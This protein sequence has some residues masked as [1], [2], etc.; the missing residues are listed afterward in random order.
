MFNVT[1]YEKEITSTNAPKKTNKCHLHSL[2]NGHSMFDGCTNL[3]SF[4]SDLS[5]LT[6][7]ESMFYGCTNLSSFESDLS[8]LTNG[9][10]MFD[11]C[12]N[13]SSFE[14]DLSSLTNGESMFYGCKLTTFTSDLSSLTDGYEM[15]QDCSNLTAFTADLSSLT[16]AENMF[17]L[18]KLTPQS[19]MYI[20][21]SIK[22]IVAEKKLYQ[23]GI[24]PYVTY[25]VPTRKY[26]AHKGFMSDGNY[27]Y[28]Y[29]NPQP[30]TSIIYASGVG[31]LTIGINVTNDAT[32]IA[33]QLQAFAEEATFNSWED[34]KQTFVDKGWN[35]TWQYCGAETS[36]TYDLRGNRAIPCP[37]YTQLIEISPEGVEYDEEGNETGNMVYTDEQKN[38]A[39]YTNEDGSKFYN[40]NWGHDVT[41]YDDFQQFDSLEDAAVAYGV[42]I[43]ENIITTEE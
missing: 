2:T 25:D 22:D 17:I 9:Y 19:V 7:G 13:L 5:A 23:D 10:G 26:S 40:I 21:E 28:T 43:K 30:L 15:F 24:I 38:R 3:E 34:L 16:Y 8:S 29:N 32:T 27:V 37:V 31:I 33:D 42:F 20:A 18:A 39:E 41:N 6:N 35:V 4:S 14:S 11:G 1:F 36:T 12:T